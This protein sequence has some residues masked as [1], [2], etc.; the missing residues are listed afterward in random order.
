[1]VEGPFVVLRGLGL[2]WIWGCSILAHGTKVACVDIL[3]RFE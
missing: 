2:E 1:M 3:E